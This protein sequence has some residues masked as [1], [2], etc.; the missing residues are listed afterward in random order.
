MQI[1]IGDS[2]IGQDHPTLIVAELSANHNQDFD[3]A[4]KTLEAAKAAGADAIKLQ[5]YTADTMT[6][7]CNNEHFTIKNGSLWDGETLYQLYQRATT[8]WEWQPKLKAIADELDLLC[9]STPFDHSALDFLE[10]M[11]MP[12]HKLAS[13]EIQDIPLIEAMAKTGKPI[14]MSTGMATLEDIELA[15][16]TCHKAGNTQLVILKCTSAY[17]SPLE[18]ANLL[19]IADMQQRFPAIIGISDHTLGTTAPLVG[20]SLGAKVIEKHF[21]LDRSLGGPDADFSIDPSE[22][23]QLVEEVRKVEKLMGTVNYNLSEKVQ[24]N[25]TFARSLFI[26]E[27]IAEGETFTA[28]N[29][30]CIRPGTGLHPKHLKDVLGKRST[31]SL[32]RGTP[33]KLEDLAQ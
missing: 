22:L 20:V 32:K 31:R 6:I 8:P 3:I 30:R 18:E 5:T 33:L 27:D 13:F 23:K 21:I 12:V 10:E 11:D 9:F 26:V 7:D 28:E 29:I 15:I 14:I 4:V 16:E 19:T 25:R 24:K 17:P 2:T 1:K